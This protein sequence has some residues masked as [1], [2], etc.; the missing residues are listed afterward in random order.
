MKGIARERR[1]EGS[2]RC[3]EQHVR[4]HRGVKQMAPLGEWLAVHLAEARV[5][6]AHGG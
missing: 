2:T 3:R 5:W 4:R 1:K 6:E